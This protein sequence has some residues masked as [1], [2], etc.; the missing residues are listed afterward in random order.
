MILTEQQEMIRESASRFA[1]QRL[2]PGSRSWE[3]AGAVDPAVLREMG[4]LGFICP[5]LPE[6]FGGLGMGCLAAG[7]IHDLTSDGKLAGA[8][9]D[10]RPLKVGP[11]DLC[12]RTSATTTTDSLPL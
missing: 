11:F 2:V 4:E 1:E 6:S 7:V 8:L 10:V 3:A 5:E 9:N 12:I